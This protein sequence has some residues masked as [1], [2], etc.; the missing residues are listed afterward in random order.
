VESD[1]SNDCSPE[2]ADTEGYHQGG[3]RHS[4]A[5]QEGRYDP[6]AGKGAQDSGA[7]DFSESGQIDVFGGA[8]GKTCQQGTNHSTR[9]SQKSPEAHHISDDACDGSDGHRIGR[10][11]HDRTEDIDHVL[12]WKAF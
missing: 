11:K 5:H 7:D 4:F 3:Q 9:E 2:G 12:G 10:S 1:D 6:N 8:I